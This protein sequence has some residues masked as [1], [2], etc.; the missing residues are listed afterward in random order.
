MAISVDLFLNVDCLFLMILTEGLEDNEL[1]PWECPLGSGTHSTWGYFYTKSHLRSF[2]L[3]SLTIFFWNKPK[4]EADQSVWSNS[5]VPAVV[6][7]DESKWKKAQKRKN[8]YSANF[9]EEKAILSPCY[10]VLS[11]QTFLKPDLYPT[12]A[13][14]YVPPSVALI[15]LLENVSVMSIFTSPK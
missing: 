8:S 13:V 10:N 5:A 2:G 6:R 9:L 15:C 1:S 12:L 14:I 11:N 4:T 3:V 7:L